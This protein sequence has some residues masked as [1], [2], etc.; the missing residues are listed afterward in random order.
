MNRF[1]PFL[2]LASCWT[3]IFTLYSGTA[4]FGQNDGDKAQFDLLESLDVDSLKGQLF[5]KLYDKYYQRN[6][7]KIKV[8]LNSFQHL[9]RNSMIRP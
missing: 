1:L 4:C 2:V 5:V 3:G 9:Y 7:K 6:N 8:M